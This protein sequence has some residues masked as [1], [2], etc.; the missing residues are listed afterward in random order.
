[1]TEAEL[2]EHAQMAYGN[3]IAAI[4][5]M[6]TITSAYLAVAYVIGKELSRFQVVTISALFILTVM[7]TIFGGYGFFMSVIVST[8]EVYELNPSRAVVP[9]SLSTPKYV[10]ALDIVIVGAALKFMR[11]VRRAKD[12]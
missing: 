6:F 3:S 2:L 10:A 8:L 11:D 1:M 9:L 12:D 5:L 7:I 4:A